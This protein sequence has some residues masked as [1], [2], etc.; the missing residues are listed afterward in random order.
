MEE[1]RENLKALAPD[2]EFL[3][4][5]LEAGT[6]PDQATIDRYG[7][8]VVR[9]VSEKVEAKT[10]ELRS[11]ST[12]D[13]RSGVRTISGGID[14]RA[15]F[16]GLKVS[17]KR[18]YPQ[19]GQYSEGRDGEMYELPG[20]IRIGFRMANDVNAG[21]TKTTLTLDIKLPGQRPIKFHYNEGR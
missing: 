18:V 13:H 9:I 17:G 19:R 2:H 14:L 16:D 8:E 11:K 1:F 20:G 21:T 6:I 5:P 15:E 10:E 3:K 4:E 7:K 12:H